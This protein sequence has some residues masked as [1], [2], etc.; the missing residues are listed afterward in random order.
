MKQGEVGEADKEM[1]DRAGRRVRERLKDA[2]LQ[3]AT[4]LVLNMEEGAKS[5]D[6]EVA[7]R[8]WKVKEIDLP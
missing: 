3:D 7:C 1:N 2:T 8:C 4:L 5:Q 6:I